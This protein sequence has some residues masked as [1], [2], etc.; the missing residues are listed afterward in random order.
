MN[1]SCQRGAHQ[2]TWPVDPPCQQCQL[3]RDCRELVA[4]VAASLTAWRDDDGS[5][6]HA[7]AQQLDPRC[8][9]RCPRHRQPSTGRGRHARG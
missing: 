9:P 6:R 7:P 2:A 8:D 4:E 1:G 3:I 5:A